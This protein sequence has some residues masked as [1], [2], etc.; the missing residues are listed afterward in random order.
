MKVGVDAAAR[1]AG[2]EADDAARKLSPWIY[3]GVC[4][5]AALAF[6]LFSLTGY[7]ESKLAE[8]GERQALALTQRSARYVGEQLLEAGP[9]R[10][11]SPGLD[12][13]L[14]FDA[15]DGVIAAVSAESPLA[16]AGSSVY[17]LV[18]EA[19]Y[20][21]TG[22]PAVSSAAEHAR[23]RADAEASRVEAAVERGDCALSLGTV[24]GRKCYIA[25]APT[26]VGSWYVCEVMPVDVVRSEVDVVSAIFAFV[27]LLSVLCVILAGAVAAYLYRKRAHEREVE[28]KTHLYA[29]LSD[30][31]DLSV[32]LFSPADG[33]VTAV[34][35]EGASCGIGFAELFRPSSAT[36]ALALSDDA[37]AFL[38]RIRGG[39]LAGLER[40]EIAFK[41]DRGAA[42]RCVEVTARPLFF[43]D[44]DQVLI[45]ARDATADK[46]M[47]LS[48][49]D[50]MEAAESANR[51]KSKFLSHMSHDIR[52]PMNVIVGMAAIARA[53]IDDRGKLERC[54]A[55]IEGASAHLLELVNEVLDLSKIESGQADS[56]NV[57][58]RLVDVASSIG[59]LIEPQCKAKRQTYACH[60]EG[61]VDTVFSGDPARV[62]RML[63]NLLTNAVKYT[64]EGGHVTLSVAVAP[65]LSPG[66]RRITFVVSDDGIGMSE[67]YLEHL[68]EPFV[69]EGRS[70]SQGTGLG[71][72]IVRNIVTAAG[73][74]IH[75][76]TKLGEGTTF[77]IVMNRR[78][79]PGGDGDL[80]SAGDRAR[81]ADVDADGAVAGAVDGAAGAVGAVAGGGAGAAGGRLALCA[82]S[83][84]PG[85]AP[86]HLDAHVLLAEDNELNAEIARELLGE[87]GVK[88][89]WARDGAA[90][91]ELLKAKGA[92]VYDA[93]LM[94][95]RMPVMNGY[96]ATR[97]IR[98]LDDP[99]VRGVPVVAMSANAFADDVLASL[100]SGM[101][102][103]LSKPIDIDEV[104]ATLAREI[105]ARKAGV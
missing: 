49:R 62:R 54:L 77:T 69:I 36:D 82:P 90:A 31:L 87:R 22:E 34:V 95:V 83:G 105:S 24:D 32:F 66:Y 65:A 61:A 19:A 85:A 45:A 44:K 92:D 43:E 3:A 23:S 6:A 1:T 99:A 101:N 47:E 20:A 9:S 96:E 81:F 53:N 30:S 12:G 29:A 51:A 13:L 2:G 5:L 27:F 86:R 72:S 14:L 25:F 8:S 94:D 37:L 46:R 17:D 26:Q 38:D 78:V 7:V 39:G 88:V 55:R 68:F 52:T 93:V 84:A 75:V 4:I 80:S 79:A 64:D 102:A 67:D 16:S 40:M 76:E 50:A 28:M 56:V 70:R 35:A 10:P 15:R 21:R 71:M 59:D 57:P 104:I 74:D 97:A 103:H 91:L 18:R 58:F 11:S 42:V 60:L 33:E 89:D 98:A 41:E 63:V 100:K 73:G 48:M